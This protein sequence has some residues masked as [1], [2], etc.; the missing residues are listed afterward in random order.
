MEVAAVEKPVRFQLPQLLCQ[1]GLRYLPQLPPQ[2][3]KP[4][5]AVKC[6]IVEYLQLPLAPNI[7][8]SADIVLQRSMDCSV[9]LI[10]KTSSL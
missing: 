3:P 9:F 5:D 8:W 2:R 1:R 6:Y 7:L 10:Y 4:V